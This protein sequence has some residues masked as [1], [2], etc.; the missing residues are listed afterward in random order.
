MS[1]TSTATDHPNVFAN[2]T[3][4]SALQPCPYCGSMQ[5]SRLFSDVRDRLEHAPGQWAFDRCQECGAAQLYP[6]PSHEALP[7]FYPPIYSFTPEMGKPTALKRFLAQLE[8]RLFYLPQYEAQ[9]SIVCN[10]VG[11]IRAGAR[12]LDVGCGRGLRLDG[13]RRRGYEVWGSDFQPE[14]VQELRARGFQ[15]VVS[16]IDH[17]T[18]HFHPDT[19]DLITAFY[20]LEHV[21]HVLQTVQQA[22]TLL[23]PGGWLAAAVPLIDGA[24][25]RWFGRKWIHVGEAPRHLTLPSSTGLKRVMQQ[26]GYTAITLRPDAALNCAGVMASSLIPEASLTHAYGRGGWAM[27]RRLLGGAITLLATPA[28]WAE[29]HVL[30]RPSHGIIF[31]RKTGEVHAHP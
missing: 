26:A 13:F 21:P 15:A 17:L 1:A 10:Q 28:A 24:Q 30:R 14:V 8:Y 5:R 6:T 4:T 19:F 16:D 3:N 2:A 11:S 18:E 7:G 20:L 22:M 23:K 25:A 9:V 27:L 31:G 29:N 12:L